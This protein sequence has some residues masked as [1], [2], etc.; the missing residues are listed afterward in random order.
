MAA[1]GSRF[2]TGRSRIALESVL[3]RVHIPVPE[4][5][6]RNTKV[7]YGQKPEIDKN[8][9]DQAVCRSGQFRKEL[10]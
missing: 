3:E 2:R 5:C 9:S 4:S 7:L 8:G 1:A 10:Y 6:I